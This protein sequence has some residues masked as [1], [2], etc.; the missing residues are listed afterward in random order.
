M[1]DTFQTLSTGGTLCCS[2]KQA[3]L[4][5]LSGVLRRMQ[6]TSVAL[7]PSVIPMLKP[8]EVLPQLK[9]LVCGGELIS[10]A[11]ISAWASAVK[12]HNSYGPTEVTVTSVQRQCVAGVAP[13]NIGRPLPNVPAYILDDRLQPVPVGVVGE[14]HFGGVQVIIGAGPWYRLSVLHCNSCSGSWY[15]PLRCSVQDPVLC[16]VVG[17]PT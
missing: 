14:L 2:P 5:D 10:T 8:E 1:F 17:R 7:T 16:F 11:V 4:D 13:S 9:S 12:L 6:I 3:M 15:V